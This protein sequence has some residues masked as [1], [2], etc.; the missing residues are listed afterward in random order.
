MFDLFQPFHLMKGSFPMNRDNSGYIFRK[1]NRLVIGFSQKTKNGEH[2]NLLHP[3]FCSNLTGLNR[4]KRCKLAA[5]FVQNS[6]SVERKSCD[7]FF[8]QFPQLTTKIYLYFCD[9]SVCSNAYSHGYH[10]TCHAAPRFLSK[11]RY[12]FI[13]LGG[14]LFLYGPWTA[15][16]YILPSYP[17]CGKC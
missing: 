13:R 1:M 12:N 2:Q 17:S 3:G 16:Y 7:S 14:V 6:S 10:R 5:V 15:G 11:T 9:L 4:E 8:L